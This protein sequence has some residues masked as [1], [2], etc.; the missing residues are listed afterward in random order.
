MLLPTFLRGA[1]L[2]LLLLISPLAAWAQGPGQPAPARATSL[3]VSPAALF[4]KAPLGYEHR[5]GTRNSLGL[6]GTARRARR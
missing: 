6:L 1:P 5:L 3:S 4:Y 2:G